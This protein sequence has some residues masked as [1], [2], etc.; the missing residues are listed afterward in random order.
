M[1][2]QGFLRGV[3]EHALGRRI[4][5]EH[6]K[7]AIP[8][9]MRYRH[10]VDLKLQAGFAI[11]QALLGVLEVRDIGE[12]SQEAGRLALRVREHAGRNQRPQFAT[13]A[14][15]KALLDPFASRLLEKL[16]EVL[17]DDGAVPSKTKSK[18]GRPTICSGVEPSIRAICGFTKVVTPLRSAIQMPSRVVSTIRR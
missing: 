15:A 9:D 12:H 16:G 17:A 1:F 13:I 6:P 8:E 18:T 3:A 5:G 10:A 2:A 11:P 4:P 14:A 7:W